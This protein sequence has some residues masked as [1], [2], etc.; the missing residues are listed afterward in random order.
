MARVKLLPVGLVVEVGGGWVCLYWTRFRLLRPRLIDPRP[1][2]RVWEGQL[3]WLYV[4]LCPSE[5]RVNEG[6]GR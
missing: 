5:S 2:H 1:G 3:G 6:E 4:Q